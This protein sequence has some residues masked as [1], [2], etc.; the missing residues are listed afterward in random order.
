MTPE[1]IRQRYKKFFTAFP[2]IELQRI[3]LR[4]FQDKDTPK[5]FKYINHPKV[6]RFVPM[7]CLPGT[8]VAAASDLKFWKDS[9]YNQHG[10]CWAIVEK[11]TDNLIG[12]ICLTRLLPIQ[13]KSNIS[14]DLN[15]DYWG[16]GLMRE[17][18]EA[19]MKFADNDLNLVRIQ[20][21]VAVTNK[22]SIKLLNH[23]GFEHEGLMKKYEVLQWKHE[24]FDVYGRVK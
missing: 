1:E 20:A 23:F 5:Y 2:R 7:D 8:V 12:S 21:N 3:V 13:Q 18:L 22:R 19:V 14:Y 16:R 24:D 10:I 15:I 6:S 4:E 17:A 11:E 9:F